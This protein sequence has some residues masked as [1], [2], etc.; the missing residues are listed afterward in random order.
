MEDTRILIVDD[1]RMARRV[2]ARALEAAGY[3]CHEAG[4]GATGL[5][6]SRELTP[7]LIL[8]D[9][10]MPRLSGIE[11]LQQLR[12]DF[13]TSHIPVILLTSLDAMDHRVEGLQAGADDYV[14]K[15][16][17]ERDLLAR[18]AAA[19]RR[20]RHSLAADPTSRLPGNQAIRHHLQHRLKAGAG[21][22]V[23]YVDLDNFKAYVD[24]YGF[25]R[26]GNVINAV[27]KLMHQVVADYGC[28]DD[29][30]GH[31]GG[32]DFLLIADSLTI[33][34]V[35]KN[36]I[37]SFDREVPS[38]YN[39]A[40]RLRGYIDGHDRYGTSRRFPLLSL[41]VAIIDITSGISPDPIDLATFA[42]RSKLDI[43]SNRGLGW[44]RYSYNAATILT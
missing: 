20:S 27:A 32:D 17:D 29:F 10:V 24:F 43:K 19:L 33:E 44:R 23:A 31:I 14:I 4:D 26:A 1:Q 7:D 35:C 16:F 5:S 13:R 3:Q 21:C 40:D 9:C 22:S 6:L 30:V 42:G 38:F 28:A 15:P 2:I 25:E 37:E 41:S 36:L 8:L 18:V 11:V 39:S 34:S 12:L